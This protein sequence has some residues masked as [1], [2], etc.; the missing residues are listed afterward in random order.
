MYI[1]SNS[2]VLYNKY[3]AFFKNVFEIQVCKCLITLEQN[4]NIYI[5]FTS[6]LLLIIWSDKIII[7]EHR[8]ILSTGLNSEFDAT[9]RPPLLPTDQ[10]IVSIYRIHPDRRNF[11]VCYWIFL[12]IIF[13]FLSFQIGN[14]NLGLVGGLALS[15]DMIVVADMAVRIYDVEGNLKTIL[16]PVP[17]GN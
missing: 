1:R 14:G 4:E 8:K 7:D 13:V 16:A 9:P 15:E 17:K 5:F 2:D 3:S 6:L 11:S 12:I 10:Q